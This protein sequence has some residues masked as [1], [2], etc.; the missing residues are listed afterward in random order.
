MYIEYMLIENLV[1]FTFV[2]VIYISFLNIHIT[3]LRF[4]IV[5]IFM[6]IFS[7]VIKIVLANSIYLTILLNIVAIYFIGSIKDI[8]TYIKRFI[9]YLIIYYLYLGFI[10]MI[11]L[12][13]KVNVTSILYRILIY[14]ISGIF[15]KF[16]ADILWKMWISKIKYSENLYKMQIMNVGKFNMLLDTGNFAVFKNMPVIIM[17]EN[18][19]VKGVKKYKRA[20][21]SHKSYSIYLETINGRREYKGY[22]FD[23]I[24]IKKE[25]EKK[26]NIERALVVFTNEKIN[27]DTFDGILPFSVLIEK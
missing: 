18:K 1:F 26:K 9:Y 2:F 17:N 16:S 13:F 11:T 3:K 5:V 23:N 7:V 4:L 14:C 25:G 6:T 22:M 19:Y 20:I 15:L 21:Y 10:F 12:V 24:S 27:N 8:K